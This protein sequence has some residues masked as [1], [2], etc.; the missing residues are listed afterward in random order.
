MSA[1]IPAFNRVQSL[2]EFVRTAAVLGLALFLLPLLIKLA[3]TEFAS[4]PHIGAQAVVGSLALLLLHIVTKGDFTFTRSDWLRIGAISLLGMIAYRASARYAL[5]VSLGNSIPNLSLLILLAGI[6]LFVAVLLLVLQRRSITTWAVLAAVMSTLGVAVTFMNWYSFPA[7]LNSAVL[8]LGLTAALSLA[9]YTLVLESL[10]KRHP[11]VKVVAISTAIGS[12]P[13]LFTSA[14]LIVQQGSVS[15]LTQG[16]TLAL[17]YL[18]WSYAIQRF[19]ALPTTAYANLALILSGYLMFAW[20]FAP[21]NLTMGLVLLGFGVLL[22]HKET[23]VTQK[24]SPD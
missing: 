15:L 17:A 19:G 13:F 6:P 3:A 8:F 23:L 5:T 21:L 2:R 22:L 11:P 24:L 14:T 18:A 10:L 12:L 1:I 20:R 4:L 7:G 16:L 9:I